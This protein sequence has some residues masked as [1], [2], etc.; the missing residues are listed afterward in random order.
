MQKCI[1][2]I[3]LFFVIHICYGQADSIQARIVL[4]GDA[5]E[6]NYGRAPVIDAARNL[7]PLNSNTTIIYLG[8]N[9]YDNGLPDDIM[10]GYAAARAV[11]DSQINI[12]KGTPAKVIFIPG[13][14]DW[15]N[16]DPNGL[17]IVNRQDRYINSNG[18]NIMFLPRD[19]C[20]GPVEYSINDDIELVI[21]DSQWFI[22]SPGERPGIESDCGFK[23][24]E[25]FYNELEDI[26]N[27]NSKKLII[28]AGHHTLKS[29]G[30]H[31]G[32]FRLKQ[33]IFPFTEMKPNLWIPL[34]VIGSLY[35]IVRGIFGT[36]EDL[37]YPAYANMINNIENI[38]KNHSNIIFVGGHEHTLQLIKDSSNYYIVSGGGSKTTRVSYSNKTKYAA[39]AL[40]FATLEISKNKNVHVDF[41]TVNQDSVHHG[42]SKNIL[43][44]SAIATEPADTS[45][46]PQAIPTANFKDSVTVA[47]NK[48]YNQVS[49]IHKF[50][51]GKNYRKEWSTPVH[52]KVFRINKQFGGFKILS[53][54]GGKQTES[55]RLQDKDGHEWILRSVDKDPTGSI[56][57][58]LKPY[59]AEN[60]MKDMITAEHPYGALMVPPL[61]DAAK[62]E[63]ADPQYY[64]VPD[65][66]ALGF[67]RSKFANKICLLEFHDPTSD[68]TETKSTAKVIDKL[69]EDSKNHM[70]QESVL[71]A[72]L[73]DMMIGDWDRHF[74]QWRFGTTDTGVGKLY[75][76]VPRDRDQAFF[77]SDGLFIKSL[78]IAALPYL[79]G[80]KKHYPDIKWFN[81]E[82][83]NFDRYFMN[84]L[85]EYAW[86]RIITKFQA[87]E[88]DTVIADAVKRL[89]PEIYKMDSA[90][91]TAKLKSRRDLILKNGIKYYRFLSKEVNVV[92]SNKNEYFKV[93]NSGDNLQVTVYKRKRSTDSASVM[94]NRTFNSSTTK[95]INL[96]GLNGNDIF[97]VD[98]TANSKIKLRIIGGKGRD[99][100]DI[101]GNVRN[102]IYDFKP[103]TNF[104]MHSHKTKNQISNDPNANLYDITGF[105]YNSYRLPL[106]NIG[107]NLE[108]G[109]NAGVGYSL[110]TYSFRKDPYSTYQAI[111][112]LYNFNSGKYQVNYNGEFNEVINKYDIVANGSL[113]NTVLNNYFGRGNQTKIDKTKGYNFYKVRYNYLSG[114]LLL[115]KRFHHLVELTFGP[116]YYHYWNHT[117]DNNGKILSQPSLAGLDSADIYADKSYLGGK[118]AVIIHNINSDLLPTRGVYWNTEISSLFGIN[119][120]SRQITK[121]TT[122]MTVYA[123]FKDPTRLVT[124]LRIG[125]GHIFSE[126]YEYFQALDLGE[127]N[128]LRGFR[129]NRFSGKSVF[130]QST[131]FRYKLFDSKSYL[132][133]GAVGLIAFNDLGRVWIPSETSH[134][135]HDSFGGGLYYSPYNFAIV[136][137]TVAFSNEGNLFNFS[138]GTK[139]NI[140]F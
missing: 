11:I 63:H 78:S 31:G 107:Y 75:Y 92:G 119:K 135:W 30:I 103:D 51:A 132:V 46:I 9:I 77:Y 33:H 94:F 130:Y 14:H 66:P 129:K 79:Q 105:N 87:D 61:A 113:F 95:F 67:Y 127:N 122:D 126:N 26:I 42:Y 138:I 110:K 90:K 24:P 109:L 114:D 55:L 38:T 54:G 39:A 121:L 36:P 37:H 23:T 53:M 22:R 16:E 102:V 83:R 12:A 29:Y 19:G 71:R 47:V 48:Q 88:T 131:E 139:F 62:I 73:L 44:F 84:N 4:I 91:I 1:L 111:T 69:V 15:N 136:S 20:P 34:P 99:T 86:K 21:Y 7:I 70:D 57:E 108:D 17:E 93:F 118:V 45:K 112:S 41:Y 59:I 124:V 56:P 97:E 96:Y 2:F 27:R 43:N 123:S 68:E 106:L 58:V 100:F 120:S 28:L 6:L 81:W 52:L 82:E 104:I 60:I 49:S 115:R 64:F 80:F 13:N 85:D 5:G 140:T 116:S 125:Y 76:P 3:L 117:S 10:P 89:P 134:K 35:P 65:D 8:D 137:A 72:R 25:Q 50:I 32:Y 40:G 101:K 98:S 128:Y 18:K 74:D 133:P